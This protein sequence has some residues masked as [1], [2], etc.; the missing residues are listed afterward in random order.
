MPERL[1]LQLAVRRPLAAHRSSQVPIQQR[2]TEIAGGRF[3]NQPWQSPMQPTLLYVADP[4]CSWCFGFAPVLSRV[5]G[6]LRADVDFRL[7]LGGLAPDD[8]EPMDEEMRGYIRD[9][10]KAVEARTGVSFNWDYWERNRPRRSTWP[11]CRAVL[12]AEDK[13]DRMF[14][15]IQNA[16]YRDA[17]DPSDLSVLVELADELGL[18][19]DE[20]R[21]ALGS[22]PSQARLEQ[23]FALRRKLGA[24]SFPS[25]GFEHGG[26]CRLLSSGWID[27]E[28]L[29]GVLEKHDLLCSPSD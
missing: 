6:D 23:H 15:A 25:L 10:W 11:A 5:R 12:L 28:S 29:R 22:A 8:E 14:A 17:R 1:G 13:Q 9:A 26:E 24:K 27:E 21:V 3:H 20:F 16:Y 4:M 2:N 19:A 7:V 18:D